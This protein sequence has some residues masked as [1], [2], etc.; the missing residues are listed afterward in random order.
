MRHFVAYHNNSEMG[1]DADSLSVVTSKPLAKQ[2]IGDRVWLI[3]GV[4]GGPKEYQRASTFTVGDCPAIAGD[5]FEY[6]L[7]GEGLVF[8][9]PV[10]LCDRE[11][12][13]DFL[14]GLRVTTLPVA[15][16]RPH[17][18]INRELTS[19]PN[20]ALR[21]TRPAAAVSEDA[22]VFLGGPVR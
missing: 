4:G 15:S 6:R 1:A 20:L 18:R 9:L 2:I 17:V 12:F 3:A 21:R 5:R 13:A 8:G 7:T 11:W 19:R 22:T 10:N 14:N 16:R